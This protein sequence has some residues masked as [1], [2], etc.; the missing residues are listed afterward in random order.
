MGSKNIH[1]S[2]FHK[3]KYQHGG[4]G[5]TWWHSLK[6]HRIWYI[7]WL[8]GWSH[9]SWCG[10]LPHRGTFRRAVGTAL[11]LR[12]IG[13]DLWWVRFLSVKYVQCYILGREIMNLGRMN[14]KPTFAATLRSGEHILQYRFAPLHFPS[15]PGLQYPVYHLSIRACLGQLP[16][17]QSGARATNLVIF[18]FRLECL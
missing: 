2:G 13:I 4:G 15:P 9:L 1:V 11:T 7:G 3:Q 18:T 12:S 17:V 10:Y 6:I 5:L 14:G 16:G 8:S